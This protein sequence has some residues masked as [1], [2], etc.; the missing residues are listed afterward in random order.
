[1]RYYSDRYSRHP[2]RGQLKAVYRGWRKLGKPAKRGTLFPPLGEGLTMLNLIRTLAVV[3]KKVVQSLEGAYAAE[4]GM[5]PCQV[6]G[7][8]P[9][10]DGGVS[11]DR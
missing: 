9:W 4:G 7:E 1:M 6:V 8:G 2:L 10:P 5:G 3:S 11:G